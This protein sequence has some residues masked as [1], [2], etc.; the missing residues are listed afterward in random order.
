MADAQTTGGYPR[1]AQVAAVDLPV[2]G[3]LRPGD[4]IMFTKITWDEA[5][6][7]YF[8]QE[9]Q[10]AEMTAAIAARTYL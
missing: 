4:A 9:R 5:E 2:C 3:Q 6:R 1:I 7:L 10:L 8:A